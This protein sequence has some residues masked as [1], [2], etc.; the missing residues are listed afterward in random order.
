LSLGLPVSFMDF[1]IKQLSNSELNLIAEK[2]MGAPYIKNISPKL[3]VARII[4]S[5]LEADKVGQSVKN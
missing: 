1:G 2:T 4:Q 5:L 3:N